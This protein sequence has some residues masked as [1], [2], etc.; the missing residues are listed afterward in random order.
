MRHGL[1]EHTPKFDIKN[2]S[3]CEKFMF[4]L[5]MSQCIWHIELI[6]AIMNMS[7]NVSM[8]V[9]PHAQINTYIL[10]FYKKSV[11]KDLCNFWLTLYIKYISSHSF[12]SMQTRTQNYHKLHHTTKLTASQFPHT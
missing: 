1:K 9:L 3:T 6:C 10:S 5:Q 4:E 2:C 12:I 8:L 11:S 7:N